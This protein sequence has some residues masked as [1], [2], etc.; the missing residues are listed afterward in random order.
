MVTSS[1]NNIKAP[2]ESQFPFPDGLS[3]DHY[4]RL[5]S[6][7]ALAGQPNLIPYALADKESESAAWQ[8]GHRL[9]FEQLK[10]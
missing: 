10:S 5:G 9:G 6:Y 4:V 2:N 8:I 7:A 1:I 3:V